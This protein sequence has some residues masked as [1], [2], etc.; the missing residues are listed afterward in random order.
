[1][2]KGN[3]SNPS[4]EWIANMGKGRTKGVKNKITLEHKALARRIAKVAIMEKAELLERLSFQARSSMVPHLKKRPD[5]TVYVEVDLEEADN[6]REI[7]VREGKLVD[8]SPAWKETRVKV[9]DPVP[10][11]L[12][13]AE[14][15]GL[16]KLP[17]QSTDINVLVQMLQVN[18]P[19]AQ[20]RAAALAALEQ[21][22]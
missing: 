4:P 13:L 9:A 18:V 17:P 10:S 12:G 2:P 20:L 11:L 16:K 6:V 5:G 14:I 3:R 15:Y 21:E 8:G 19:P 22:D 7:A 1:M